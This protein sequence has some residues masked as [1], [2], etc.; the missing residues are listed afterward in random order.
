MEAVQTLAGQDDMPDSVDVSPAIAQEMADA[1]L[2]E[3]YVPTVID[4]IPPGLVD[5][6]NNWTAA[7]YGIMAISTNTHDRAERT[8]D[9]RRSEEAGVR[10]RRGAQRRPA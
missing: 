10:G 7:Y 2:F 8:A 5:V 4:E 3:P 9:V 1:G 6:D